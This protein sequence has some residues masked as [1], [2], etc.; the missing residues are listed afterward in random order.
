MGD[1]LDKLISKELN[2]YLAH[3]IIYGEKLTNLDREDIF[4]LLTG[5][6]HTLRRSGR[7]STNVRDYRIA[8]QYITLTGK[9]TPN[10]QKIREELAERFKWPEDSKNNPLTNENTFYTAVNRGVELICARARKWIHQLENDETLSMSDKKKEEEKK[11]FQHH[12]ELVE[13]Y[14]NRN[15]HKKKT[16]E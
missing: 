3:K 6:K 16:A 7:P 8:L 15:L 9:P 4:Y 14:R 1:S 5:R 12:L 13:N 11:R 10:K 2:E